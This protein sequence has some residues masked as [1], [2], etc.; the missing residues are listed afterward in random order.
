MRMPPL[1]IDTLQKPGA[2]IYR[3][4]NAAINAAA[5]AGM[6]SSVYELSVLLMISAAV[7]WRLVV[8]ELFAC[9]AL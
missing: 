4:D 8:V 3:S 9:V 7:C 6:N 5:A 2:W 1:Y